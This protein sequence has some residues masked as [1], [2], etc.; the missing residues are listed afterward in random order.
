M[1]GVPIGRFMTPSDRKERLGGTQFIRIRY[2]FSEILD[3]L[4]F[5]IVSN[6][7]PRAYSEYSTAF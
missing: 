4:V 2:S 3:D 5:N 6:I 7:Y 1:L